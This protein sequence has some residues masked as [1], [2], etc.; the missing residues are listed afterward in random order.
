MRSEYLI[1]VSVPGLGCRE[2]ARMERLHQLTAS[3]SVATLTPSLPSLS[4]CV[5]TNMMTGKLPESHGVVGELWF[6][7]ETQRIEKATSDQV[8][9]YQLWDML[10]HLPTGPTSAVWFAQS[11]AG[12]DADWIASAVPISSPIESVSSSTETHERSGKRWFYTRPRELYQEISQVIGDFPVEHYAGKDANVQ[13]SAWIVESLILTARRYRP[14]FVYVT[15]PHL[16]FS[17]IRFG[18]NTPYYEQAVKELDRLLARL[19]RELNEAYDAKPDYLFIG[20]YA[21][22]NVQKVIYPNRVLRDQGLLRTTTQNG[23]VEV[24][25]QTSP[26]FAITNHQVAH[27]YTQSQTSETIEQIATLFRDMDGVSQVLVGEELASFQI[28]HSRCGD[29]VLVAEP[30]AWF[31]YEY[32][33]EKEQE[34]ES[35]L[36]ESS[37]Q[38]P[39]IDPLEYFVDSVTG[40]T[41]TDASV[42]RGSF[43]ASVLDASK[44][45]LLATTCTNAFPKQNYLD[46]EVFEW[47]LQFFESSLPQ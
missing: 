13:S 28:S 3:G 5:Q 9:C 32:R 17:G 10:I 44:Q 36:P 22:N 34:A 6:S 33:S 29:L 16:S 21:I 4:S 35:E 2:F 39:G 43:G 26:A 7:R 20:E 18:T 19:V 31:S 46:T 11:A 42:V 8:E 37:W 24:S 30:D 12:C 15:L 45:T 23:R 14:N 1:V 40:R 38:K 41:P 47:I 27:L 25:Y